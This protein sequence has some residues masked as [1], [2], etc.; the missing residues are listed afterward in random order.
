MFRLVNLVVM[1][2]LRC[3]TFNCRG[4]NSGVSTLKDHINSL[5][6]YFIQ[7]HWLLKDHLHMINDINSDFLSISVSGMD[8]TSLLRGRPNGVCSILYGKTL[9]FC[10]TPL[11]SCSDRFCGVKLVDSCGL[12]LLLVSLYLPSECLPSSFNEYL[13]TL[14]ELEGFLDCDVNIL[15]GDFNVDFGRGGPLAELLVDFMSELNLYACDL[16]WLTIPMRE[17]MGLYIHGLT[18]LYALSLFLLLSLTFT[19]FVLVLTCQ[20]VFLCISRFKFIAGLTLAPFLF[21]HLLQLIPHTL[22]GPKHLILI[23]ISLVI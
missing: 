6:L 8:N 13:N 22:I 14:G 1:A 16:S 10:L 4:W 3:C 17:M 9:S 21:P 7:E 11:D 20:T 5:D 2:P 12:S 23:L 19:L 15:V 18:I